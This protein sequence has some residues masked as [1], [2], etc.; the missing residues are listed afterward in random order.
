MPTEDADDADRRAVNNFGFLV[1]CVTMVSAKAKI[2]RIQRRSG[3]G[4]I[5]GGALGGNS[6]AQGAGITRLGHLTLVLNE[7]T[8]F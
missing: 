6:R 7:Q 8:F 4:N 5:V 2:A 3:S 1:F